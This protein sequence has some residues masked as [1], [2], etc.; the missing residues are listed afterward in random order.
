MHQSD[1]G[2]DYDEVDMIHVPPKQD[3][4][5]M[6]TKFVNCPECLTEFPRSNHSELLDH[7]NKCL[8]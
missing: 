1:N 5:E 3:K 6:T 8:K 2:E 7:M 4:D